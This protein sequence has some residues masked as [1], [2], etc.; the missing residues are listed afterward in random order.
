MSSKSFC[1][2][3]DREEC[4]SCTTIKTPYPLQLRQKQDRLKTVLQRFTSGSISE[5]VQSPTLGFRN[6]AKLSVTGTSANPIL[7]LTGKENLDEGRP[8][9]SCLIHHEKLN[10]LI[11]AL[12]H[13]ISRF[14]LIPYDISNRTGELKSIILFYSEKSDEL[15]LR[16]V[17]RSKECVSRI[18]KLLPEL[19]KEFPDLKVISANIQ[20]IPH[21]I[22]EGREE[23]YLTEKNFIDHCIG[24][25]NH[26]LHLKLS[27]QA[28]VQT[29]TTVSTLL[30]ETAAAWIAEINPDKVV[31]LFCGQGPFSFF[32][33]QNVKQLVGLE[34]NPDAV[35]IA[36]QTA[37]ELRLD[38]LKFE[39]MDVA[40][41]SETVEAIH[42]DLILVNPP[43]RG[44]GQKG[45]EL[46]L[47]S[48]PE[49]LI[50]SSCSIQSLES[51]LAELGMEYDIKRAQLF[52]MFPHTEHFETLV[53]LKHKPIS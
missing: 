51:D 17:L 25:S 45:L 35:L 12:P 43:R 40:K 7:G 23:I 14:N 42:P 50:Y 28:F 3:F 32:A 41:A 44:L 10:S 11:G 34:I 29:N 33:A 20:P 22:L 6:K 5:P 38:H 47:L 18:R 8:I 16:F 37:R 53:L 27:P 39:C 1:G 4:G 31:D 52:D 19:Q 30:Y 49:N 2:Y 9:L 21:A 48:K 36:N 46:L 24:N 13:Y 15:Y 26:P